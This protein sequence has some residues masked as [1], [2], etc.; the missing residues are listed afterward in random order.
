MADDDAATDATAEVPAATT[1]PIQTSAP[2]TVDQES[3]NRIVAREKA[4]AARQ[5]TKRLLEEAGVPTVDA[6]KAMTKA[7]A[8]KAEAEKT[9][10][11]R[12]VDAAKAEMDAARNERATLAMER[13]SLTVERALSAA[14][15]R[16]DL[17]RI[18]RLLDVEPGADTDAI[19]AAVDAAKVEFPS[20]FG[21]AMTSPASSEPSGGGAPSRTARPDDAAERGA[22]RAAKYNDRTHIPNF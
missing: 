4:E 2:P 21:P 10:L 8:E 13:H 22:A 15:A 9:E 17:V 3:F 20:L 14:G 7:Q 16:G 19:N 11:Q 5:A 6:L 18:G 12:A 1:E